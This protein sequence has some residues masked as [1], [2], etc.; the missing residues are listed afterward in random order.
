MK[1]P[2]PVND[3]TKDGRQIVYP[4]WREDLAEAV[5]LPLNPLADTRQTPE[6]QGSA[7]S[8]DAGTIDMRDSDG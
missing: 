5:I 4:I 8:G 2:R 7:P 3:R 6:S 1:E